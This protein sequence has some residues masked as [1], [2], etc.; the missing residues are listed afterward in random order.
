ML[1]W[2]KHNQLFQLPQNDMFSLTASGLLLKFPLLTD[3]FS[4]SKLAGLRK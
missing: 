3:Y 1:V 2:K 4:L